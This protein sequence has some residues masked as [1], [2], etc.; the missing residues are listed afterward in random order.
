MGSLK[1]QSAESGR[2]Q[3]RRDSADYGLGVKTFKPV[4][5]VL[6]IHLLAVF[7]KYRAIEK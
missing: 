1:Q 2:A 7:A 4:N 3:A 5:H 6:S